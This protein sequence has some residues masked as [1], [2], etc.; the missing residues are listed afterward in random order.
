M[1]VLIGAVTSVYPPG[2]VPPG[3]SSSGGGG[4]S[5]VTSTGTSL[6]GFLGG[7][8]AVIV[9]LALLG[10]FVIVVVANRADPDP[11]GRRPRAVYHFF[12]SF[13][14]VLTAVAGSTVAVWSLF[15]LVG[16][17]DT[18]LG[19]AIARALVL[20][21]LITLVSLIL[22]TSHRRRGLELARAGADGA[23]PARRVGQSYVAA[24]SFIFIL[25]VLVTSILCVYLLF[26]LAG[27]GVFG[28]FGGR[29]DAFRDFLDSFYLLVLSAVV[30]R[31]HRDLLPPG[32]WS[33]ASAGPGPVPTV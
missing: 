1:G 6:F 10:V 4:V 16:T 21:G 26:S 22:L 24:I 14:T 13:V 7:L 25:I 23:D 31:G 33:A 2:F 19:D 29:P 8:I 3:S 9:I 20:G 5:S 28:S 11:T 17:H 27:P 12:V 18:A 30:L 15:R 32:L